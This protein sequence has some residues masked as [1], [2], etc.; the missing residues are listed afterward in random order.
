MRFQNVTVHR[1]IYHR[2][3]EEYIPSPKASFNISTMFSLSKVV[4]RLISSLKN[5]VSTVLQNPFT[6]PPLHSW[7]SC[8]VSVHKNLSRMFL[9]LDLVSGKNTVFVR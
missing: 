6:L 8:P 4:M 9:T 5:E 1:V 3:A 7:S 2:H